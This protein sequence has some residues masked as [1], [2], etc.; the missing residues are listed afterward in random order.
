MK[1]HDMLAR[2]G[3]NVHTVSPQQTVAQAIRLLVNH[4]IGSLVVMESGEIRGII[5]E[6]DVLRLVDRTAEA[7]GE[8]RVEEA[9]TRELIV[10]VPEDDVNHVMDVMTQNRVRHLPVV[11]GGRL[12][13]IISIG[14]VVNELRRDAEE[15]NRHLKSY[16]QGMVR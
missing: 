9:M 13:G 16:V 8:V 1:I 7:L 4:G 5:T 10:A 3:R 15:E 2:K 11:E 14:D 12:H 6:R